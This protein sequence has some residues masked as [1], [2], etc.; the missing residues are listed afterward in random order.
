MSGE[1]ARSELFHPFA[2]AAGSIENSAIRDWKD[3]G[4][5]VVGYFCSMIPE[6]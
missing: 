4:G 6:A 5:K 1:K 2:E 3:Q